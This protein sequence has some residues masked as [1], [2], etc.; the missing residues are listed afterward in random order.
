MD[1]AEPPHDR[2]PV[3]TIVWR[4]AHLIDVFGIPRSP[5]PSSSPECGQRVHAAT[6]RGRPPSKPANAVTP[7]QRVLPILIDKRCQNSPTK[8]T[9]ASYEAAVTL[10]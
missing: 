5:T 4:P 9:T 2:E 6:A 7:M 10:A 3:T 1:Y 8:P